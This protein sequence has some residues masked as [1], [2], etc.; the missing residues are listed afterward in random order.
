MSELLLYN[1]GR[2][3]TAAGGPR[4]GAALAEDTTASA[5]ALLARDGAIVAVGPRAEVEALAGG[6]AETLDCR[7]RLVTPGLVDCHTHL[8]YGGSRADEYEL[9]LGGAS[10]MEIFEAGGGIHASVR[11]TRAASEDDLLASSRRRA[12]VFLSCGTTTAEVKSGYGLTTEDELKM[13]RATAR[14]AE[15]VPLKILP[16][17]LGAH[18]IP[19]EYAERRADFVA[20]VVDEMIPAVTA[21]GLA[22]YADV[23]CDRG[24]FDVAETRAILAAARDAGLGLRLHA[25]EFEPM[26][27]TELAVEMG[28]ASVEHLAVVTA[29]GVEALASSDTTAVILPGTT[30]FLGSSHFAPARDLIEAGALVAVGSDHNPGSCHAAS[31]RAVLTPAATYLK[32]KPAEMLHA[33]TI[34]AAHS[35]GRAGRIGSLEPGKAADVAVFDVADI[36]ELFYDWGPTRAWATVADGKVVYRDAPPQFPP[37]KFN[38]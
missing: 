6:D 35:L 8:V 34:N 19:P 1:A 10:Y 20:L 24:A 27:G 15:E 2:I 38:P 29:A 36:N 23:F 4:R 25:D 31:L 12:E 16:T 17:F 5:D 11:A 22:E 14:L 21:A 32:M 13:L 37:P 26:G 3:F 28:A 30:V 33:V 7:G 18:A 9:R